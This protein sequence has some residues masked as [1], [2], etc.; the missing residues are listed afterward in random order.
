MTD[1][2]GVLIRPEFVDDLLACPELDQ[3]VD[4]L[5][6]GELIN[7]EGLSA[8][9][10][11]AEYLI[12]SDPDKARRLATLCAQVAA[13]AGVPAV[14]PHAEYLLA[15]AH[16][17]NAEYDAAL[18]LIESARRGFLSIDEP[19]EALRTNVG[20]ML[21]LS[22]Q[23]GYH[24]AIRAGEDLL[25][26]LDGASGAAI[27]PEQRQLLIA[28]A[29][30]NLGLSYD[31]MGRYDQALEAYAGAERHYQ[32]LGMTERVGE[33]YNNRGIVLLGLGR[34]SEALQAFEAAAELFSQAGLALLYAQALINIGD[35]HLLLSNYMR[36]LDALKQARRLFDSLAAVAQ[37]PILLIDTADAYMA[38][39][40][41][42]EALAAY[43]EAE[44]LMSVV[45]LAHDRARALWGM[46]AALIAQSQLEA[47][48]GALDQAA[49]LFY[50]AENWPLLA[51]VLLEQAALQAA[52][53]RPALALDAA[54]RSLDLV[55]G[56]DLPVQ[57]VYAHLRLADL[58]LPDTDAVERHLGEVRSLS[59]ALGLPHLRYRLNQRLG[60]LRLLQGRHAEA[61]ALLSSAIDEIERLRGT[62]A[63]E[64]VRTSF[65]HDKVTA[66]EDLV[67]LHLDCGGPGHVRAA[68]AAAERS[69]SRT[70]VDLLSGESEQPA[71]ADL[72]DGARAQ[73]RALQADLN[74]TYNELLG[75]DGSRKA[76][77]AELSARASALEREMSQL[78]LHAALDARSTDILAAP[79][80]FE[81]I[82]AELEPGVALVAYHIIGD[83]IM[84]FVA[85]GER[86]DV[87]RNLGAVS[88]VQALIQRLHIQWDRF[89]AGQEF[90][91]QHMRQLEQTAQRVLHALYR[92]LFAPLEP[93][94]GAGAER[95]GEP[96]RVVVVPHGLLHQLPFQALYDGRQYLLERFE[97]TYAPSATVLA[98]CQRRAPRDPGRALVLGLP[99][100]SIPAVADEAAAV[101][102]QLPDAD[103]RLGDRATTAA[104]REAAPVC[105]ILHL[106][107]HGLF[108]A[109]SPMFSA[110]KLYDGWLTAADVSG[111]DLSGALVTLSACESGR[112]QVI[113][114]DEVLGLKRAFLSAGVATLV[115]GLWLVQDVTTAALMTSWY[116]RMR[117]GAERA[118]ALRAA[119]LELKAEYS[120]PY[121]WAPFIL[122]GR[123]SSE[124]HP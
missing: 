110:L 91:S 17:L 3:Q 8:L 87:V 52:R 29:Q 96:R 63:H 82:A 115:V 113:G 88:A 92:A 71:A 64:A 118:A 78:R 44:D 77:V 112:S 104:V 9:L 122:V 111:I 47:A 15:R 95:A 98:L 80:P 4:A 5:R 36:G 59:D 123:R 14:V 97:I 53:G 33:I 93:L 109:D 12:R 2:P 31:Q 62:L 105:G 23:G 81:T 11:L 51:G 38:L 26:E 85:E 6:S 121:Y 20:R 124:R 70:L 45:G 28:L 16:A 42:P 106:A 117:G 72:Q 54:R 84:A 1:V 56:R 74:A 116:A 32:A 101:A 119:Q 89:R 30:Q 34:G 13:S 19:L 58:L 7:Q 114:G 86:V 46:G 18:A 41:H 39:N 107:C 103:L 108:R 50:T 24:E 57:Q 49:T 10:D 66:Y 21:V 83:E 73:L 67:R 68:F 40:L 65:L 27:A 60:H 100:L 102:R 79:L 37:Q 75:V 48:D 61:R 76:S 35:A 22:E 99:D 55:A 94:L 69:K 90:V 43:R 120:H 25:G